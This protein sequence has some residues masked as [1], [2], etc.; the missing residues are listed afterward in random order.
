MNEF[1]QPSLDDANKPAPLANTVSPATV[2]NSGKTDE[3]SVAAAAAFN[4]VHRALPPEPVLPPGRYC[5]DYVYNGQKIHET[6]RTT[7][8]AIARIAALKRS[9][10]TPSTSTQEPVANRATR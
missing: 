5:L 10:I 4:P 2:D 6:H 3:L 7:R 9:G 8:T 1:T